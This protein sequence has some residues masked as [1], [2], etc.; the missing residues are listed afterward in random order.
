[1]YTIFMTY[2]ILVRNTPKHEFEQPSKVGHMEYWNNFH[3]DASWKING[4]KHRLQLTL[5]WKL[6]QLQKQ[7][8]C[9][10]LEHFSAR[11]RFLKR[12][13]DSD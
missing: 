9:F 10:E 12:F 4:T 5:S 6:L 1:M 13:P 2:L 8:Y 3:Y 7:K 11:P